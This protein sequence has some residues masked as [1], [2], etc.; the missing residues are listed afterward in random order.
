MT[1]AVSLVLVSPKQNCSL[2]H[3]E[4][5]TLTRAANERCASFSPP[6]SDARPSSFF[7]RNSTPI[8]SAILVSIARCSSLT[9]SLVRERSIER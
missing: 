2:S 5:S 8:S 4:Y 1:R 6:P 7:Y 3:R 9:S